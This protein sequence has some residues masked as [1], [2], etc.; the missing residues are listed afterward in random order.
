[1]LSNW[2]VERKPSRQV[3]GVQPQAARLQEC[4][5]LLW[6]GLCYKASRGVGREYTAE[7]SRVW[8]TWKLNLSLSS[9]ASPPFCPSSRKSR[10]S[11]LQFDFSYT[12]PSYST[13]PH[14]TLPSWVGREH[15][16]IIPCRATARQEAI[17]ILTGVNRSQWVR[18]SINF[19]PFDCTRSGSS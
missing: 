16:G 7:P 3:H 14:L 18:H 4:S 17:W 15:P 6:K 11:H 5:A 13:R 12:H 19:N 2:L 10:T 8:R 9:R 1:M